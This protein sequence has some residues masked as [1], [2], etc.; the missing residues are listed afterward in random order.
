MNVYVSVCECRLSPKMQQLNERR[1]RRGSS[2]IKSFPSLLTNDVIVRRGGRESREGCII[3][4]KREKMR[5]M[6]TMIWRRIG[7]V[8]G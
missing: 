4:W 8:K 2:V 1:E 6:I 3:R 7:L 5:M